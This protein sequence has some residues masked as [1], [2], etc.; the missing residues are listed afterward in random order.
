[1]RLRT[2]AASAQFPEVRD[3]LLWL[4]EGYER[5]AGAP[6]TRRLADG[7]RILEINEAPESAE[8]PVMRAAARE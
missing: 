2:L 4:A 1:M 8:V 5:L 6:G 7:H 3:E